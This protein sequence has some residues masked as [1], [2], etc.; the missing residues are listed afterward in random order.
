MMKVITI[1]NQMM[2]WARLRVKAIRMMETS[3]LQRKH[4]EKSKVLTKMKSLLRPW[5]RKRNLRLVKINLR[6]LLKTAHSK[7][8]IR[9][10]LMQ[11]EK[12]LLLWSITWSKIPSKLRRLNWPSSKKR[13]NYVSLKN[14]RLPLLMKAMKNSSIRWKH[15]SQK[16]SIK[17]RK[18]LE[19]NSLSS[20]L[21][22]RDDWEKCKAV[23]MT[24]MM[25]VLL[26]C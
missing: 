11:R 5:S 25:G 24:M 3:S 21:K 18:W 13:P 17:I 7:A 1:V 20:A 12:L 22:K 19:Q 10:S 8:K 9:F 4:K 16:P 2:I 14:Q 26:P 15:S 23:E 6:K